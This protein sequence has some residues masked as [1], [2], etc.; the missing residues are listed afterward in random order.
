MRH[1]KEAT[2]QDAVLTQALGQQQLARKECIMVSGPG[3]SGVSWTLNQIGIEWER[4]GGR[5]LKATGAAVTHPRTLLP[6]LTMASPARSS[7]ARWEILK[8]SVAEASKAIPIVGEAASYVVSELLNYRRRRLARQVQALGEKEQDIL[9]VIET[10]TQGK[11]LLLLI[12]QLSSWDA[13]S[14][15]LL[16]LIVSPLLHEYYPSL[17]D[18]LIIVGANEDIVPRCRVLIEELPSIECR[19]ARL[20]REHLSVALETFCFPSL[21]EQEMDLLYEAT[22]G[23]LDLLHDFALLCRDLG[24]A[25]VKGGDALYGRMIER[26]LR[27][28]KGDVS[29]LEKLLTVASFLGASFSSEEAC[30]L[31]DYAPDD[32]QTILRRAEEEF[33]LGK[34]DGHI[35]FPSV[36]MQQY[37]RSTRIADPGKYHSKFAECLRQLRPGDYESRYQHL[38]LADKTT[39]ALACYCLASL[40]ACRCKRASP[41]HRQFIEVSEWTEFKSYLEVMFAAYAKLESDAMEEGLEM[42]ESLETFLPDAL[43]AERDY[44]KARLY[45]RSHRISSFEQAARA[46]KPWLSLR[47]TEPEIWS[48]IAQTLIVALTETDRHDEAAQLE[49]A[50]TKYYGSR[51]T[52]DPWAL[53]G[54]NCLRRR[55]ECLHQLVPARNRLQSALAYFGP[56]TTGK[57]PRHPLQYYY[58]LVN[59][60]SNLIASGSF[61]EATIRG[62][63][64]R[65]LL[66]GHTSF[67]W[68]SMEIAA[69]NL[70]LA[71]YL[72]GELPLPVATDLMRQ[73]EE[74]RNGIGDQILI[75]NNLAVLLIHGGEIDKAQQILTLAQDQLAENA[76]SD[77][78]HRY[79]VANN[80]A[81]VF[82]LMGY[83]SRAIQLLADAEPDL[84]RLY[85]AIRATLKRRHEMM[86]QALG[87]AA[88]VGM[89]RFDSFLQDHYVPQIG[90]QWAFYGRTFLLSDIQFWASD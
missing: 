43:I 30:C 82:A 83:P 14:W 75:N 64:L 25:E 26:R 52:L 44:L 19:L 59:L 90:P 47:D 35:S 29:A 50:L 77:A 15:S 79:F 21:G 81:G 31:M 13:D 78:Y 16:E 69:N 89:E 41:D 66:Q 34:A 23:R 74:N 62:A 36:A 37:F 9:Y 1:L 71:S 33:L 39:D 55:S 42:L 17:S 3:G 22:G 67:N 20:H 87:M 24:L 85:P 76:E 80:L 70:I 48:R 32:L 58:T 60:V 4:Q 8:Q 57:L 7:L 10:A 63:E 84:D 53:Y 56:A 49:E 27:S 11:R 72:A 5:A 86:P 88:D 68:P 45:L 38:I 54:L 12:D 40:D 46:L 28:L 2:G 65:T 51:R 6:W 18:A 61:A 73:I